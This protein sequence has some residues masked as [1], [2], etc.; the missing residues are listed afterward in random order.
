MPWPPLPPELAK[1]GAVGSVGYVVDVAVFN[2]LRYD[3]GGWPGP[4]HE[5]PVVA[6]A[7]S[8]CV[9]T[10]VTY[11]GHRHWTWRHGARRGLTREYALFFVLNG[12]GMLI[13]V[14]CLF[15]SHHLL[16]LTSVL[17][18]NVSANVVGL[19]LGTAFRFWSYRRF[20]FLVNRGRA[21]RRRRVRTAGR[22]RGRW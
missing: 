19:A 17:A 10:I 6:K 8:V 7:L 3:G 11:L 20:V 1:F 2:L 4:L 16:G 5:H 14:G 18:D 13:A 21:V 9:A 22:A 15:V 12:V